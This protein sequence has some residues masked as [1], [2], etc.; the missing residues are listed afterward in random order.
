MQGGRDPQLEAGVSHLLEELRTKAFV[1]PKRPK[2]PDRSGVG[3][4][5]AD[6]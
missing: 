4:T 6:R 1:R 2:S 3:I 5:P